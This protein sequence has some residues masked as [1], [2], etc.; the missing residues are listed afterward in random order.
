MDKENTLVNQLV[1]LNV[2]EAP[3]LDDVAKMDTT[4]ETPP[5]LMRAQKELEFYRLCE[6]TMQELNLGLRQTHENLQVLSQTLQ[7]SKRITSSWLNVWKKVEEN[8]K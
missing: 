2:A 6:K 5:E 8:N 3:A 7:E 4:E 1:N